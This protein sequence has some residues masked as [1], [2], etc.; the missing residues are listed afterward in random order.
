MS[1]SENTD[2]S[3]IIL[4]DTTMQK[5]IFAI[6]P[7]NPTRSDLSAELKKLTSEK[8]PSDDFQQY[9]EDM[10][11]DLFIEE[12]NNEMNDAHGY[13]QNLSTDGPKYEDT[14]DGPNFAINVLKA[15]FKEGK[16]NQDPRKRLKKILFE[17]TSYGD[18]PLH[19]ALRHGK[20][21]VVTQILKIL[22][23]SSEFRC[24]IDIQNA[25]DR[26]PLHYAVILNQPDIV[27]TLLS[28]GAN[29]NTSDNHGSYPLHEAAKRP[30]AYECVDAL[31][32]AKADFNVRDDTGWTPLQ[33][34]AEYGSL[35]AI[36][37]LIKAGVDVNSTERSFGRT[38]L[39]IAVEGGHIDVVRYLLEKVINFYQI[40]IR[41]C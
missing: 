35:R 2:L 10:D 8:L 41:L 39:H 21:E 32:D 23:S 9:I 22:S 14:L 16:E 6:S 34:A 27:R 1:Y 37:S 28:I 7:D 26:T 38:A 19:S 17:R 31:L 3:D 33:V 18:T 15:G 20:R 36:A 24:L 11:Y 12:A 30:Q 13:D 5:N 4:S 25:S 29:P 40:T